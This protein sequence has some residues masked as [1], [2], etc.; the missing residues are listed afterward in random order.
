V[1]TATEPSA[2]ALGA[3]DQQRNQ[4]KGGDSGWMPGN[5]SPRRDSQTIAAVTRPPAMPFQIMSVRN[6]TSNR[7]EPAS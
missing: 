1:P 3:D 6:P 4:G 2:V 5:V 7:A